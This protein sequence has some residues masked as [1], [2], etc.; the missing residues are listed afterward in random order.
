MRVRV[1]VVNDHSIRNAAN[2]LFEDDGQLFVTKVLYFAPQR[3]Y[4]RLEQPCTA[5]FAVTAKLLLPVVPV[6]PPRT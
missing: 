6:E 3:M 5:A 4:L 1:S 2:V